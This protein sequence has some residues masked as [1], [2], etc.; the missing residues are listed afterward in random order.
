MKFWGRRGCDFLGFFCGG[1]GG[2]K[3]AAHRP[4]AP[5]RRAI[6]REQNILSDIAEKGKRPRMVCTQDWGRKPRVRGRRQCPL[7]VKGKKTIAALTAES[8]PRS[9]KGRE[10]CDVRREGKNQ[11]DLSKEKD[12]C[13]PALLRGVG[14]RPFHISPLSTTN[15]VYY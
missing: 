3:K 8:N 14:K 6:K 13:P 1:G 12:K 11:L 5:D 7:A 4:H 10:D 15:N 2:E 9:A